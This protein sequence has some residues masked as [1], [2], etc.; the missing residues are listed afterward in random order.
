MKLSGI[1]LSGIEMSCNSLVGSLVALGPANLCSKTYE[2][3]YTTC[4]LT[5]EN[6]PRNVSVHTPH[7][8]CCRYT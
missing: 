1:E 7:V 4:I 3:T 8:S 6:L 5:R 2:G